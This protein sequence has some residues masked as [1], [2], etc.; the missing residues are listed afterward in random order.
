MKKVTAL[1]KLQCPAGKANP[2]PPVGPALGQHGLNIMQFCKEFNARTAQ[3]GDLIIPVLDHGVR[4]PLASPSS[5]RRHPRRSCSRRAG[6]GR[7][8]A[9]VEP[10]KNKVGKVTKK[11]V[12]EIAEQKL[13]DL[14]TTNIESALRDRSLAPPARWASTSSTELRNWRAR[15]TGMR[16]R[17]A[18]CFRWEL[19]ARERFAPAGAHEAWLARSHRKAVEGW[20]RVEEVLGR[21]RRARSSP[22]SQDLRRSGTRRSTSRC[23]WASTRSTPT[24]WSRGS[25]VM[26]A[27]HRARRKRVARH[28]QGPTRPGRRWRPAPTIAGSDDV[29][30]ED[31]R[32]ELVRVRHAGR[33]ART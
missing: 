19:A 33:D 13:P 12:R 32:G 2:A 3:M 4:G 29:H 1:I 18:L 15:R 24:R 10:N 22:R 7:E 9:R 28:R 25:V 11:Q 14:N 5:P 26:P 31:R 21:S 8:G 17:L 16:R 20:D 23:A 30:Q 6:E 27:R